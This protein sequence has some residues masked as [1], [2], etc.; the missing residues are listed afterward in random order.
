VSAPALTSTGARLQARTQPLA[1]DDERWGWPHAALCGGL[2]AAFDQVADVFDPPGDVPPGAPLLDV[3]L[4]PDWALPWLAQVVGVVL[5]QGITA[6]Q[7]RTLIADVAGWQRGTPGAFLTG[8]KTVYFN[9]R[10]GGAAYTLQVVTL[11]SETP[12]PTLVLAALMAQKPGGIVLEYAHVAAAT[13]AEIDA[14]YATYD[15][16][17]TTFD[18]YSEVRTNQPG[19]P[20]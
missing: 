1:P 14:A 12:D 13:Y 2:A 7:S 15:E 20:L 6:E 4:C 18:D 9:E 8:S 19:G 16:V 11:D 17:R 10:K 3:T 5:P